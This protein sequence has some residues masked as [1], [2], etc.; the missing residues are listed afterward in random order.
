MAAPPPPAPPPATTR[1]TANNT[2]D[3]R[4]R[5]IVDWVR[6]VAPATPLLS[7]S[8]EHAPPVAGYGA[9]PDTAPHLLRP[10]TTAVQIDVHGPV[11]RH[12]AHGGG[13]ELPWEA[14][15][16]L[17]PDA[18]IE[19]EDLA[20]LTHVDN[21]AHEALAK[22]GFI[23]GV[24]IP[25]CEFMWSVL[26][27][28]R[29]G[30]IVGEAGL[31]AGLAL[32][33]LCAGT[34]AITATS[35]AAI[36]TNGL[37]RDGVVQ[38]MT[39]VLGSGIGGTITLIFG[40]GVAIFSSVE[41]VGSVQGLLEASGW[42]I[43]SSV[44]TDQRILS[45]ACL[46][47]LGFVAFLG[48]KAVYRLALVF[49][50]ALIVAYSSLFAGFAMAPRVN[51]FGGLVTG[52]SWETLHSNLY[53]SPTL[54]T[55][56]LLSLLFPCFLGIFTGVNNAS[57]LRD[58]QRAIPKGALWAIATSLTLYTGIFTCLAAVVQRPLL[59][60][61]FTV[62]PELAWPM[63]ALSIVGLFLVGN[64]SALH[65]LVLASQTFCNLFAERV[66]PRPWWMPPFEQR[67][68]SLA[69]FFR[70]SSGD[71]HAAH[72]S[73]GQLAAPPHHDA[74]AGGE[75]RMA[76]LGIIALALPFIFLNELEALAAIVAMCFLLSYA[77]TNISCVVLELLALPVW[78]PAYRGYHW[79]LSL[80][81]AVICVVLMMR[82]QPMAAFGLL[83]LTAVGTF[84]IQLASGSARQWG[85]AVHG[86][87]Y[88][89]A[90]DHLLAAE[91]EQMRVL[92]RNFCLDRPPGNEADDVRFTASQLIR[93]HVLN[94]NSPNETTSVLSFAPSFST[95]SINSLLHFAH[96]F[97]DSPTNAEGG[98]DRDAAAAVA[99]A[100]ACPTGICGPNSAG[101][102]PRP[103]NALWKPQIMAFFGMP[104]G[105]IQHPRLL[106][107]VAQLATRG[108]LC[109]LSHIVVPPLT[110]RRAPAERDPVESE[111]E[112]EDA[113]YDEH[114][115]DGDDEEAAGT[116]VRDEDDVGVVAPGRKVPLV[117]VPTGGSARRGSGSEVPIED[118]MDVVVAMCERQVSRRKLILY[119]L[120][121]AEDLRGFV[122]VFVAP[123]IKF[124]QTVLLQSVG[125]G[126]LTANTVL[127]AWPERGA[128]WG[129]NLSSVREL[130][131]LW[132]L[133][134]ICGHNMLI[135]KGASMFP[136]NDDAPMRGT[137][138]V[139]WVVNEGPLMLLIAFL[140][141]QHNIWRRC[142]LRLFAVCRQGEDP[143]L[144][145]AMLCAYLQLLRIRVDS[146]EIVPIAVAAVEL[147]LEAALSAEMRQ[148]EAA[149]ESEAAGTA[150]SARASASGAP[151]GTSVPT[152]NDS[153]TLNVSL[154]PAGLYVRRRTR[155]ADHDRRHRR[156]VRCFSAGNRPPPT[157][158][159]TP[160]MVPFMRRTVAAALR[161]AM[162][163][164]SV[165]ADLVVLNLP[166][167]ARDMDVNLFG[168]RP[169]RRAGAYVELLEY[170]TSEPGM[171]RCIL[172]HSSARTREELRM[173][174][175]A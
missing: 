39:R 152:G 36:A 98:D 69:L 156:V 174:A 124:G 59:L 50:V 44:E 138:D 130:A 17:E 65:C 11:N 73:N 81:G 167:V 13:G 123:S 155:T 19:D 14:V 71:A 78:R 32:L 40:L 63:P 9:I 6:D 146:I 125:L 61:H 118:R 131:H 161:A 51:D 83:C 170:L 89:L 96:T 42:Q 45:V 58:P 31:L 100:D 168:L 23:K 141:K 172:V 8:A 113:E 103:R 121:L 162:V 129:D 133:A 148:E 62:A 56:E 64:G 94:G 142:R 97:R 143:E 26:I 144:L 16:L 67:S 127:A 27:F 86:L 12:T 139:W 35:V 60:K 43:T 18:A 88:Q 153:T 160:E 82:I 75:P 147:D 136:R 90:L 122:K 157:I 150:H 169:G 165:D 175:S 158:V 145:K 134:R 87:L 38:V 110:R 101:L 93:D 70:K 173:A 7:Q 21:G 119:Q 92:K 10:D 128:K 25:T 111:N 79:L 106:A 80:L 1:R 99:A 154:A 126:E 95:A 164:R 46:A 48:H 107:L 53:P 171:K 37:P 117:R 74:A 72:H 109:V 20:G 34:V 120:M 57:N 22:V 132:R 54:D 5:R 49:L 163:E 66:L 104:H 2:T 137:L 166:A 15:A 151:A 77:V 140:L 52:W 28:V 135:A 30:H 47:F 85:H 116:H 115:G 76:L 102:P 108:G 3:H 105:R 91:D 41:V 112:D 4:T 159:V 55:T 84:G 29:F 149:S 33:L 24:T 114:G 68:G